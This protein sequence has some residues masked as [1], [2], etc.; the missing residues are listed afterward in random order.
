[1]NR[2]IIIGNGFDLAHGLKTSYKDFIDWYWEKKS[3]ELCQCRKRILI[4]PLCYFHLNENAKES[5]WFSLYQSHS[6]F[7]NVLTGTKASGNEIISA[8]SQAP[9]Y[10][11]IKKS[12]FFENICKS[13]ETKGWVDIENEY[14][15]LLKSN[16]Q[17]PD[18]CTFTV[19]DLNNQLMFLQ[20]KLTEY[21]KSLSVEEKLCKDCIRK[22]IYSPI[23]PNDVAIQSRE[24][25]V[26]YVNNIIQDESLDYI[27]EK[28]NQYDRL[29]RLQ[30]RDIKN[31][32]EANDYEGAEYILRSLENSIFSPILL[33]DNILILSFN[34]TKTAELYLKNS[35]S[36]SI[37]YIHGKLEEKDSMIFGYGDELD[38]EYK[39]I[40]NRN[41]NKYLNNIKSIKYLESDN[42]RKVLSFIESSPYQVCVMGHSC[43]NS[44]RTLLNTLFEHRNCISIKPYY[45]I[46]DDGTDN[47]LELAQNISRNFTDMKLMRDRVVNKTYCSPLLHKR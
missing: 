29:D 34:Y 31:L 15:S 14:Y 3:D 24:L 8:F 23:H 20:E 9:E 7:Q 13:I 16:F 45:Y 21:L 1:M 10:I 28:L 38:E 32:W 44:D 4:D 41:D 5:S 33:P 6:F 39:K 17:N 12:I 19:D 11:T 26:D 40:Q 30:P 43:G 27:R 2:L 47:Y 37:N 35:S 36:F 46:K 25:L 18:S 22:K 42:Y